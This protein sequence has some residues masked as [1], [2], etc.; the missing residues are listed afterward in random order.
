MNFVVPQKIDR[1]ILD[2]V[3]SS[4]NAT[5]LDDLLESSLSHLLDSRSCQIG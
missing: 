4:S 1:N 5:A 2:A 3:E